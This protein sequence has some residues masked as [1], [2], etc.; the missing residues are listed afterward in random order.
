MR[1]NGEVVAMVGGGDYADSAFNRVTQAQ[2]QPGST[3]KLFVYLAALR[4]GLTPESIVED[5]PI[6]LGD[7]TPRNHGDAYAGPMPLRQAF[8][9]SSNVASARLVDRVGPDAVIRAARDL[10]IQSELKDD[11]ML[12]LGVSETNLLELTAAYAALGAPT[13]PVRPRGLQRTGEEDEPGDAVL[14]DHER[15]ALL[16][17]LGAAVDEGTGRAAR[18]SVPAFGKTGTTQDYRDAWFIGLAG[19]LAVGVWVGNDDN[20]PMQ[21]VTGGALPARMWA[22]FTAPALGARALGAPREREYRTAPPASRWQSWRQRWFGGRGKGK[23]KK[24]RR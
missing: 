16:E 2:R 4:D 22:Q 9:Q 23:G 1:T 3:F 11:P 20:A 19:D 7:W 8:A 5:A 21:R 14:E 12:A 18:L 15:V 13:A 17:L 6:T 24:H 10:G